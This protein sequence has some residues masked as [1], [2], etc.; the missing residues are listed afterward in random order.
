MNFLSVCSM[1]LNHEA[2]VTECDGKMCHVSL[3]STCLTSLL[4]TWSL[5]TDI[6][7]DWCIS[8]SAPRLR[9]VTDHQRNAVLLQL[10]STSV[11]EDEIMCQMF[12][13]EV[14]GE[15]LAWVS[16]D[17]TILINLLQQRHNNQVLSKFIFITS[18]HLCSPKARKKLPFH[19]IL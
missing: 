16:Q 12:W 9:V 6:W 8:V 5:W 11:R 14:P 4:C 7:P 1:N 10:N 15:F 3:R 13:D 18:F 2:T 17:Q 19:W